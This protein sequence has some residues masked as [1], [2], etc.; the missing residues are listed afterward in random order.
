MSDISSIAEGAGTI[1]LDKVHE[2]RIIEKDKKRTVTS[3]VWTSIGVA[4]GTFAIVVALAALLKDSCPYVYVHDGDGF[5][6]LGETYGGEYRLV[7]PNN[8]NVVAWCEDYLYW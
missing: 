5:I 3:Y 1:S 7:T 6:F 2:V 8:V 4:A